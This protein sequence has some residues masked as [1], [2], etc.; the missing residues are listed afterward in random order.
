MSKPLPV[1][2][3]MQDTVMAGLLP[4]LRGKRITVLDGEVV[5]H[6]LGDGAFSWLLRELAQAAG[7]NGHFVVPTDLQT[8]QE[9]ERIAALPNPWKRGTRNLTEQCRMTRNNPELAERMKR[10]ANANQ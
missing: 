4:E 6:D 10:E 2:R 8:A 5:K 3:L 9:E 7:G 1:S